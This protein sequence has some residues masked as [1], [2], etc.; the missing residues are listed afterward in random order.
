LPERQ[1]IILLVGLPGS[2]KSSWLAAREISAISSDQTRVQLSDDVTNQ[3]IHARVFAT[4]RYLLRQRIA[5]GLPVTYVD[6][7]HLTRA[8]R[9]PYVRIAQWYGCDLEAVFFDIPL[10]ECLRRNALRG[11]VVP[12]EA[13][14]AMARKL[15]IPETAE[16]FD[17]IEV[18]R[19]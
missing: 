8:E 3:N 1:R 10:E 18:V 16:G 11:R 9:A 19:S 6:A 5:I 15:Q 17:R 4:V 2:G 7:T 13:I 12:P 14:E